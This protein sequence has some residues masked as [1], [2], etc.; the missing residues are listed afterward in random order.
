M[1]AKT[2]SGLYSQKLYFIF[3]SITIIH[4]I[5]WK[6][7]EH[8]IIIHFEDVHN[9]DLLSPE[10]RKGSRV[11][12]PQLLISLILPVSPNRS[13]MTGRCSL[14][15][16]KP[17]SE[18]SS[19]ALSASQLQNSLL[20][21]HSFF[22]AHLHFP[23]PG[24]DPPQYRMFWLVRPTH[25]PQLGLLGSL[26]PENGGNKTYVHIL[27]NEINKI[28]PDYYN[29]ICLDKNMELI[30]SMYELNSRCMIVGPC[31]SVCSNWAHLKYKYTSWF[32]FYDVM[33]YLNSN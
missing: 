7:H 6:H 20:S 9:S 31:L 5:A 32:S 21:R 11:C 13:S 27:V 28:L 14:W 33:L 12:S 1:T 29:N 30:N 17:S 8:Y 23:E 16:K 18:I 22:R 19:S 15:V 25:Q 24:D 26:L 3:E 10:Q 4:K 2:G